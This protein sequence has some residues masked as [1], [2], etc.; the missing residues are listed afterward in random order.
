MQAEAQLL[1]EAREGGGRDGVSGWLE[2]RRGGWVVARGAWG[3]A[4]REEVADGRMDR[5]CNAHA[6]HHL[7]I[8]PSIL[9]LDPTPSSKSKSIR[10]KPN[11]YSPAVTSAVRSF[12][13]RAGHLCRCRLVVFGCVV[14]V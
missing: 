3:E 4:R 5:A 2:E 7:A 10:R 8:L 14:V 6:R 13:A 11:R 1:W 12:S 9:D